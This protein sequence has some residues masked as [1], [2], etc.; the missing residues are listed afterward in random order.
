M[1]S[2]GT[3]A[4]WQ[5]MVAVLACALSGSAQAPIAS[6]IERM[7]TR[8]AVPLLDH[9]DAE[10]RGEAA[11]VIG[12]RGGI[13][14]E[15]RLLRIATDRDAT[16][17]HRGIVA[18]GLLATPNAV[19]FLEAQLD[20]IAGRGSE[21]GAAAAFALGSVPNDRVGTSIARTLPLFGRG[22]WKRQHDVLHALLLGMTKHPERTERG[23]L[24]L[25][26]DNEANRSPE[27]RALLLQLLLPIDPT[28]TKK[29]LRRILLRGSSPEKIALVK[30]IANESPIDIQPWIDD[31][32]KIAEHGDQPALRTAALKALTHCKHLP[33]LEIAARRL[34]SLDPEECRQATAS[35]LA[36]SG[37]QARGALEQQLLSE[38][39]PVRIEAMLR[40]FLAPPSDKLIAHAVAIATDTLRPIATRAAA[41]ELI[42]RSDKRRATPMLRDLF[43]VTDDPQ[44]LRAIARALRRSE[45]SPTALGRLLDRR[46]ALGQ[47]PERWQALLSASH[48]GAQRQVLATLED[49]SAATNSV[50]T[51]IKAW[52]KSMV[53]GPPGS[54]APS[55][56]HDC[57]K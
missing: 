22:S 28:F 54:D 37:A 47:H 9:P 56:I 1:A 32:V 49:P 5:S 11:I 7:V 25:L 50:R 45:A 17:R 57:L 19:H 6:G 21:D 18:L 13:E 48:G 44:I 29:A 52:R 2:P 16:A 26:F 41:A 8:D 36:I 46:G 23:A 12:S 42:S 20:S 39:H 31:L 15:P 51:A 27:I 33:A 10:T 3:G 34:K 55:T 4:L 30:W 43:R 40:G 35:M 53:L 24:R 38:P 14:Q